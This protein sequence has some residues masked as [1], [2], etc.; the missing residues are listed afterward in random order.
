MDTIDLSTISAADFLQGLEDGTIIMPE[1]EKTAGGVESLT[2]EQLLALEA[3]L[4]GEEK[5]ADVDVSALTDEQL[6]ELEQELSQG[7]VEKVAEDEIEVWRQAG[8]DAARGMLEKTAEDEIEVWRQSGRDAARGMLEKTA[9]AKSE[10]AESSLK[11]LFT[12]AK[13]REATEAL[14]KGTKEVVTEVAEQKQSKLAKHLPTVKKWTG[15]KWQE[16]V[17]AHKKVETV[18]MDAGDKAQLR[19]DRAR[20]R[21]ETGAAY[22]GT[23][24]GVGAAALAARAAMSKK[25]GQQE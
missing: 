5:V 15:A 25:K 19:L 18:P 22:T 23:A 8:R 7:A 3:E 24:A 20:G 14:E 21:V 9:S 6:L 4:S 10:A 13:A 2:D 16:A 12:G 1:A 17:P 11:R